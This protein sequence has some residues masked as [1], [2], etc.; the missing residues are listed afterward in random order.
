[1]QNF[2]FNNK[3]EN[4]FTRSINIQSYPEKGRTVALACSEESINGPGVNT[5]QRLQEGSYSGHSGLYS[6]SGKKL[7]N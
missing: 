6:F 4:F 1:M 2:F 3:L 5:E 7:K